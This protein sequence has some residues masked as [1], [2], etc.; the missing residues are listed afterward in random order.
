MK[1]AIVRNLPASESYKLVSSHHT[2]GLENAE[3]CANC[4]RAIVEVAILNDTKGNI[5]RVGMDCAETLTCDV[6][7]LN[8]HKAYFADVKTF[9]AALRK[10]RKVD[11]VAPIT[12][13]EYGENVGY[14]KQ[15]GFTVQIG[16]RVDSPGY[17]WRNYPKHLKGYILPV[18]GTAQRIS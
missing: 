12:L 11:P 18:L 13:N 7:A 4:G 9:C 15:G 17:L 6:W 2:G 3:C 1:A 10:S 16:A 5:H 8:E 14:Y